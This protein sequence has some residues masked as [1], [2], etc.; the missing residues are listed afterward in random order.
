[1]RGIGKAA[2]SR[3]GADRHCPPAVGQ[4]PARPFQALPDDPLGQREFV[5][6]PDVV[7]VTDRDV[8][9]GGDTLGVE[10]RIG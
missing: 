2:P 9:L 10:L 5:P 3:H 8:V 6:R 7:Q 1:V 4:F